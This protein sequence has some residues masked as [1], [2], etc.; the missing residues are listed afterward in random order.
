[1]TSSFGGS[2][3]ETREPTICHHLEARDFLSFLFSLFYNQMGYADADADDPLSVIACSSLL[4][5]VPDDMKLNAS[6]ALVQRR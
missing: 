1:M 4:S 2:T 3:L 6:L 5:N